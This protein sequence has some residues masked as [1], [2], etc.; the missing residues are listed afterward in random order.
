VFVL[1]GVAGG[2]LLG[3]L[4]GGRL[5][6]LGAIRFEWAGLVL[7]GTLIQTALFSDYVA[8]RIGNLGPPIY[9]ASTAVVL[10]AVLRN[11]RIP[12]LAVIAAGAASNLAAIVA[13]GGYM[14][15]STAA[16][17]AHAG[18]PAAGYSNSIEMAN[19]ALWPLTDIFVLPSWLPGA[20]VFSIGDVAI[21]V[22]IALAI[23]LQMRTRE[24]IHIDDRMVRFGPFVEVKPP[25]PGLRRWAP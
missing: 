3:L 19:P 25:G 2:L 11:L 22:G 4:L 8:E 20:N 5:G 23:V 24:V 17:G 9:V 16:L 1:Y 12:G 10:I 13:N 18:H 6:R 14:P 15:V 7:A 21:V